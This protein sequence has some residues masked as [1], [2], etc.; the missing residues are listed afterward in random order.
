MDEVQFIEANNMS[1]DFGKFVEHNM[2][3]FLDKKRSEIIDKAE[4]LREEEFSM[5]EIT[6]D[7]SK[8]IDEALKSH[9][10]ARA[11][12]ILEEVKNKYVEAPEGSIS[13]KRLYTIMEQ[14]YE[15]IKDYESGGQGKSLFETIHNYEEKGLFTRPELFAKKEEEALGII[16][17]SLNLKEKELEDITK[18]ESISASDVESAIAIY[19]ELKNLVGKIPADHSDLRSK[20]SDRALGWYSAIKKIK[21][22]IASP[23]EKEKEKTPEE[24]IHELEDR[25]AEIRILKENIITT[26]KMINEA[27]DKG[28]L[29]ESVKHYKKLKKLCES[30]PAELSD[31][32]IALLADA[33]T[34]Y[35]KVQALKDKV[36]GKDAT[37]RPGK[38]KESRALEIIPPKDVASLASGGLSTDSK[39]A[40][41]DKAVDEAVHNIN[42]LVSK[43]DIRGSMKEYLKL[44]KLCRDYPPENS[45]ERKAALSKG[46][47]AYQK[48]KQLRGT[49]KS[50]IHKRIQEK[51][52][53]ELQKIEDAKDAL[54]GVGDGES[55]E[56]LHVEITLSH[57]KISDMLGKKDV[58]GAMREYLNM[59]RLCQKFPRS[60]AQERVKIMSEALN[61]YNKIQKVKKG[62]V[63]AKKGS[64]EDYEDDSAQY[65]EFR[66]EILDKIVHI[67]EFLA[68][69]D[70]PS[71]IRTYAEMKHLF[72]QF[73]E[74]PFER[75]RKL[76]DDI[77]GAHLDM[78]LLDKDFKNKSIIDSS[79]KIKEIKDNLGVAEGLI[80]EKR[81]D[82]ASHLL[83]EAKHKIIMLPK[84]DFDEKYTLMREVESLEHNIVF[85]RNFAGLESRQEG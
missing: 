15:S 10:L 13:K 4:A 58:S 39:V 9:D 18:K 70:T 53:K 81:T 32:R 23:V 14:I 76:Y 7:F 68:Q 28:D 79:E 2:V 1:V 19:R 72:N 61:T 20:A 25:L 29:A 84:E 37:S 54:A 11:K 67:K 30:F 74:E 51:K 57:R 31:E 35:E 33:M 6:E 82:D 63:H 75:K 56:K 78:N 69:K 34:I 43:K 36:E 59:K 71:A 16:L 77:I 41:L 60:R 85:S 48:I 66:S 46:M 42:D 5:F 3:E 38:S 64:F 50:D 12:E 73:P 83:L 26:H 52:A 17:S 8:E 49:R 27:L 62:F 40:E 80:K 24:E 55:A 21:D 45:A 44:K 47:Q 22:D 65:D